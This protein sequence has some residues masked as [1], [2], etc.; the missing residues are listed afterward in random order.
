MT[1]F[2]LRD[3]LHRDTAPVPFSNFIYR[4][5]F[6]AVYQ[7]CTAI[8]PAYNKTCTMPPS[9]TPPSRVLGT[10]QARESYGGQETAKSALPI[11]CA[12]RDTAYLPS[13]FYRE[14]APP[15]LYLRTNGQ[16]TPTCYT[17][18]PLGIS[19]HGL[20]WQIVFSWSYYW[21]RSNYHLE[22]TDWL[23]IR[24]IEYQ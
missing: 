13:A 23:L 17:G 10:T 8:A 1:N 15:S 9:L 7:T 3:K 22:E 6:P 21:Y 2:L 19:I 4:D 5:N 11:R 12:P 20:I 24:I 16:V 18:G 14:P